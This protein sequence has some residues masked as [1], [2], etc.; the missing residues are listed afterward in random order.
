MSLWKHKV[1]TLC[2]NK[3][4]THILSLSHKFLL[5]IIIRVIPK[6]I[7]PFEFQF[8]VRPK[9]HRFRYFASST[10]YPLALRIL[11]RASLEEDGTN[12]ARRERWKVRWIIEDGV[13]LVPVLASRNALPSV[14]LF[15]AGLDVAL[16]DQFA[17][18]T[19]RIVT[20]HNHCGDR[21]GMRFLLSFALFQP[22]RAPCSMFF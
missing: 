15:P 14:C 2:M 5:L 21:C 22:N 11:G 1:L 3:E 18:E 17:C 20:G 7:F 10:I 8:S 4:K 13:Q 9:F 19:N 12:E 16:N 6:T